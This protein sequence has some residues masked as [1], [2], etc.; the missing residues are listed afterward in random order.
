MLTTPA[1]SL[2]NKFCTVHSVPWVA[3]QLGGRWDEISEPPGATRRCREH[4]IHMG[5]V[6]KLTM[7]AVA[8]PATCCCWTAPGTDMQCSSQQLFHMLTDHLASG[9]AMCIISPV[10]HGIVPEAKVGFIE[11]SNQPGAERACEEL[12]HTCRWVLA[13]LH[14]HREQ[15]M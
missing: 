1:S 14:M 10:Q 12:T 8:R 5:D 15:V 9:S 11:L 2:V 3:H 4:G 6:R 13:A 7:F